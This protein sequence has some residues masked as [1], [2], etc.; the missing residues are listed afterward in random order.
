MDQQ[1]FLNSSFLPGSHDLQHVLMDA[2]LDE[3]KSIKESIIKTNFENL[4][5][6]PAN[7]SLGR[8]EI[9]KYF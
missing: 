6:V 2:L 7:L 1:G 3:R 5:L 9:E 4:D 8:I